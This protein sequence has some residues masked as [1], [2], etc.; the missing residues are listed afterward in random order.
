MKIIGG[1]FVGLFALCGVAISFAG[2]ILVLGMIWA[3]PTMLLW[4]W[5][6]PELFGLKEITLLQAWGINVLSGI[7]F[8]G[9]GSKTKTE[10][11]KT[12]KKEVI[13]G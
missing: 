10:N 4:D 8:K 1:I 11:K 2:V 6:M 13:L 12:G 5:L 7:L 3:I 9:S